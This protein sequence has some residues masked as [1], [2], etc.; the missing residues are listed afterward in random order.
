MVQL[1]TAP[2]AHS[3]LLLGITV[4]RFDDQGSRF[5]VPADA[6]DGSWPSLAAR[7]ED[8][9]AVLGREGSQQLVADAQRKRLE[10]APVV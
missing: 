1:E 6:R 9:H 4:H 8:V 7:V 10:A 5:D 2:A 3:N